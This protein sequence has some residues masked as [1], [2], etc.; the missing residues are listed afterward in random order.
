MNTRQTIRGRYALFGQTDIGCLAEVLDVQ[1]LRV[2]PTSETWRAEP[3][4]RVTIYL[5]GVGA[6]SGTVTGV[7]DGEFLLHGAMGQERRTRIAT[8]LAWLARPNDNHEQRDSERIVPLHRDVLVRLS[9][10]CSV[11][12]TIVD[13]SMG[14]AALTLSPQPE[15]GSLITVGKRF[16][17]VVRETA[18]G[19][20]VRFRLP[21][22]PLMFNQ[23]IIL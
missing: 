16:A 18:D 20:G 1:T 2:K 4:I 14:G 5:D 8:R 23:H 13:L 9:D 11:P 7:S 6:I 12:A 21:I 10:G 17:T 15:V 19:V 22:G 3:G